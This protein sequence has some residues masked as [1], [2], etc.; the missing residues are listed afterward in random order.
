M[1]ASKRPYHR[2]LGKRITALRLRH[3]MTQAELARILGVSQQTIFSLELGERRLSLERV[4]ELMRVF[5]VSCDELLGLGPLQ[6]M[7]MR[8]VSPSEL[9]LIE[10][11]RLLARRDRRVVKRVAEALAR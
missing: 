8:R 1:D 5:R 6:P 10:Q 3:D 9:R 7:P 11:I 4:P 2:E